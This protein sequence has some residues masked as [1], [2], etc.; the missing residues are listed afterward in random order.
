MLKAK[1]LGMRNDIAA[2]GPVLPVQPN[3]EYDPVAAMA[4]NEKSICI[5]NVCHLIYLFFFF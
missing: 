4:A 1:L 2:Q 3:P 5:R